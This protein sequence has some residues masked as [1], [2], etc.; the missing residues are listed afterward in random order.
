[1]I[2]NEKIKSALNADTQAQ[3]D[4]QAPEKEPSVEE[5]K[6]PES[7]IVTTTEELGAFF[8]IK[9]LL[10][11]VVPISDISYKDTTSYIGI[12]YQ[13]KV[14]KWICRLVLN[15]SRKTLI[16]PDESKAEVKYQLE[17]I[18]DLGAYKPQLVEVVK[19]YMN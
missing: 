5:E 12:L 2:M 14:T 3:E 17:S 15:S 13:G 16:L 18:Y 8:I 9:S 10:K 4:N 6:A 19:R 7:K 11:D 1:M